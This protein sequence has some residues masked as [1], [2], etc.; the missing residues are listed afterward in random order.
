MAAR[1]NAREQVTALVLFVVL[2]FYCATIGWRGVLLVLDGRLVPVLLG[3]AV[4][5]L[6]LVTLAAVWRLVVFARDGSAMMKE[7]H[8]GTAPRPADGVWR[9]H[10]ALAEQHRQRKDRPAEQREYRAAVRAW[11]VCPLLLSADDL[12]G[13][14][15]GRR[16][17]ARRPSRGRAG[18]PPSRRPG[19]PPEERRPQRERDHRHR[20]RAGA[21]VDDERPAGGGERLHRDQ[22]GQ[23]RHRQHRGDPGDPGPVEPECGT[24]CPASFSPNAMALASSTVPQRLIGPPPGSAAGAGR[25]RQPPGRRRGPAPRPGRRGDEQRGE[26]GR[27]RRRRRVSRVRSRGHSSAKNAAAAAASRP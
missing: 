18:R 2:A 27:R 21:R 11:R 26:G 15:S 13:R 4:I 12:M 22:R 16:P 24:T 1:D 6:P 20:E 5:L 25:R 23:Q 9:G 8:S 10:L 17:R 7:L 19:P 14:R 3:I